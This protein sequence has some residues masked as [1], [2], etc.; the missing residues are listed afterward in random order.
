MNSLNIFHHSSSLLKDINL[1]HGTIDSN[2]VFKIQTALGQNQHGPNST[3]GK[4]ILR[5]DWGQ[6]NHAP[7]VPLNLLST[8]ELADHTNYDIL[9]TKNG[10]YLGI[11]APLVITKSGYRD[12]DKLY[13]FDF[14][15]SSSDPYSQFSDQDQ[16]TLIKLMTYLKKTQATNHIKAYHTSLNTITEEDSVITQPTEVTTTKTN[17]FQSKKAIYARQ[18]HNRL[19]HPSKQKMQRII[20]SGILGNLTSTQKNDLMIDFHCP[21]CSQILIMRRSFKATDRTSHY[22]FERLHAD[23]K[24]PFNHPIWF[25]YQ[26]AF[27][28]TDDFSRKIWVYLLKSKDEAG[29]S[30]YNFMD[31]E[32]PKLNTKVKYLRI[33]NDGVFNSKSFKDQMRFKYHIDPEYSCRET[34]EMN[35]L[36]ENTNRKIIN[37]AYILL[38]AA[39]RY[40]KKH[41]LGYAILFATFVE[42]HLPQIRLQHRSPEELFSGHSVN[43][44][45]FHTFGCLSYVVKTQSEQLF[46]NRKGTVGFLVG[47]DKI[48]Y[49]YFIYCPQEHAIIRSTHVTFNEIMP[50]PTNSNYNLKGTNQEAINLP[51]HQAVFQD[52]DPIIQSQ[53]IDDESD[54]D[55][56]RSFLYETMEET[57]AILN[58]SNVHED[59]RDTSI[60]DEFCK[61]ADSEKDTLDQLDQNN[62]TDHYSDEDNDNY[63]GLQS[64]LV[65]EPNTQIIENVNNNF[66]DLSIKGKPPDTTYKHEFKGLIPKDT[67]QQAIS[68]S[69]KDIEIPS[70]NEPLQIKSK[71]GGNN[72][73]QIASINR[74]RR[75]NQVNSYYKNSNNTRPNWKSKSNENPISSHNLAISD[76]PHTVKDSNPSNKEESNDTVKLSYD[77]ASPEFADL[78]YLADD[79]DSSDDESDEF[80]R[81][82]TTESK[83]LN[84]IVETNSSIFNTKQL[85]TQDELHEYISKLEK[86]KELLPDDYVSEDS[87]RIIKPLWATDPPI[88]LI[89]TKQIYTAK[90]LSNYI[91]DHKNEQFVSKEYRD[92]YGKLVRTINYAET[93]KD[94]LQNMS[95]LK[96]KLRSNLKSFNKLSKV[97]KSKLKTDQHENEEYIKTFLSQLNE[98][99]NEIIKY[100][101]HPDYKEPTTYKNM[102]KTKEVK[103]WIKS[104]RSEL[105][106]LLKNKTFSIQKIPPNANL[107]DTK[108]IFKLKLTKNRTIDKF[109]SRLCAKGFLQE[110]GL[111]FFE[112]YAPVCRMESVRA[113]LALTIQFNLILH[114]MDVETAFLQADLHEEIYMKIPQGFELILPNN[115]LPDPKIYCLRLHKSIYGLKQA[116][117]AWY[118]MLSDYLQEIGFK[119]SKADTCVF[120]KG[121]LFGDEY[122]TVNTKV[123]D[124]LITSKR[125][126]DLNWLKRSLEAKFNIKDLGPCEFYCGM[127]IERDDKKGT[128]KIHQR[129][130]VEQVLERFESELSK[131]NPSLFLDNKIPDISYTC[132]TPGRTDYIATKADSP[133]DDNLEEKER[134]AQLPYRSIIGALMYLTYTRPD[135]SYNLILLSRFGNNPAYT[136]FEEL[137]RILRYIRGTKDKGLTYRRLKNDTLTFS[138]QLINEAYADANFASDIDDRKSTSGICIF[139]NGGLIACSSTKQNTVSIST[140]ESEYISL[141][142]CLTEILWFR[143]LMTELGINLNSPHV[144]HEDNQACISIAENPGT[145]KRSKHIDIKYHFIRDHVTRKTIILRYCP[146]KLQ[147]ADIL[148]KTLPRPQ[149]EILREKLLGH[150]VEYLNIDNF[151]ENNSTNTETLKSKELFTANNLF[152]TATSYI[153]TL[154]SL[155][156]LMTIN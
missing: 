149:F 115:L 50:M 80:V 102:M 128:I 66:E 26:Y 28:I 85:S 152:S 63:P 69:S 65:T 130:Y 30:L 106:S 52:D 116:G 81:T 156:L 131:L 20:Q 105:M 76:L 47:Y 14:H 126:K 2:T 136:H 111:D 42:N 74:P 17:T 108:W 73:Q 129:S 67:A 141:S 5:N 56:P 34:P 25:G 58:D 125:L 4:G 133:T 62:P 120:I 142:L 110:A 150:E 27:F 124:L 21:S 100:L 134:M 12:R 92:P 3:L 151:N 19:G 38:T 33:D 16:E 8:G 123:D 144:V 71:F 24:G 77:P 127:I 72:P 95:N 51:D 15:N 143:N 31:T 54:L 41:W 119:R 135:I 103:Q 32:P 79:S 29:Q 37:K 96:Q 139:L 112:S 114:Q 137:L 118:D 148:T 39:S 145:T 86:F 94:I 97:E 87:I 40:L 36:A 84:D 121:N 91:N 11:F 78:P 64:Q 53:L 57:M 68:T 60:I 43:L 1:F 88:D 61:L 101:I 155:Y 98:E 154:K 75:S 109:K 140:C 48:P 132:P 35:G 18:M 7:Q 46:C 104:T 83:L 146:S 138:Q 45:T 82:K 122:I 55:R 22:V 147:I 90:P 23:I 113:M 49:M 107:V 9:L 99:E 10:V 70:I 93:A 89:K 44:K 153:D 117:R 13:Y 59:D 6:A